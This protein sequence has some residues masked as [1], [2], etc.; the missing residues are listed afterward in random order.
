MTEEDC[1][2]AKEYINGIDLSPYSNEE[3]SY[4]ASYVVSTAG[5]CGDQ[6]MEDQWT[7][8]IDEYEGAINT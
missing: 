8:K 3:R 1:N 5:A 4:L 2:A 6:N 7:M